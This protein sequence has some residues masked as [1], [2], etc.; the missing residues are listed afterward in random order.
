MSRID[1]AHLTFKPPFAPGSYNRLVGAQIQRLTE[2]RQVAIS[3]WEHQKADGKDIDHNVVLVSGRQLS[4]WQ[5]ACGTL[6]ERIRRRWFNGI[7]DRDSLAYA[8]QVLEMLPRLKPQIIVC[9]DGY[10]LGPL[11]R[12]V[13]DW[14][15]RV[16]LS[17][18][19]LSY[20]LQPETSHLLYSLKSFDAVWVLS[21]ASYRFDRSRMAA[22]EPTVKVLPNGV[23]VDEYRPVSEAEKRNLRHTWGLP[24]D[25]LVVLLL[26]RLV[27]K[28]GAHLILQSWSK[29]ARQIP[30]AYLWIAGGG[31]EDYT[32][33]LKGLI[34]SLAISDIVRLQGAVSPDATATCYQASDLY[35]FPTL[36]TE[37]QSLSLLEA[38]SCGIACIS[39]DH[40]TA[41]DSYGEGE[42][43]FVS[44]PN[45]ED[46]FV[47]PVVRV[48]R[49]TRLREAMGAAA[50][51]T[52]ERKYSYEMMFTNL[53]EFY[54][55]QL[56]LLGGR[57]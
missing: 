2:Y 32:R 35:L 19:G 39:S 43:L 7:G 6:P 55:Q 37:G 38:M 44:D 16:I 10:K 22:Y 36:C 3:Y 28:K 54:R 57:N 47:E 23:D 56:A 20:F 49:D 30:G 1:I 34:E 8:W 26:S 14:E 40:E 11:L 18:H 29:I 25:K 9:Y 45:I 50:R 24:Q 51:A 21:R 15:C 31:D 13:I 5:K 27:A 17:Q 46:A 4:T 41:R 33:Y 42:L 53:R 52:V 48:L 12:R